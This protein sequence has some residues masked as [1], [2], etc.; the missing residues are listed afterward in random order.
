MGGGECPFF[1]LAVFPLFLVLTE[2]P[3]SYLGFSL[4]VEGRACQIIVL[5]ATFVHLLHKSK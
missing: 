5:E 4:H 2:L 1:L 3:Q